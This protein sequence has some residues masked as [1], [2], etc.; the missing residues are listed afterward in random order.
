M[1]ASEEVVG[2]PAAKVAL[3]EVEVVVLVWVVV[4]V[5]AALEAAWAEVLEEAQEEL[6]AA[7]VMA[8]V[9]ALVEL[10]SEALVVVKAWGQAT[11]VGKTVASNK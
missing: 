8:P 2:I 9:G 4:H 7:A 10:A 1:V 3:V 11:A 5:T 6:V